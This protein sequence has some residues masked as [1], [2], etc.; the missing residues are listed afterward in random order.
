[1]AGYISIG[2]EAV[3]SFNAGHGTVGETPQL[4]HEVGVNVRKH[5]VV[6]A[7]IDNGAETISVGPVG[8]SDTGFILAAGEQTPPIYAESTDLIEVV[9][10]AAGQVYSWIA[11]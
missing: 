7:S 3:D 8:R 2:K 5:V 9:G 10:S 11:N 6:R 4:L 1:M